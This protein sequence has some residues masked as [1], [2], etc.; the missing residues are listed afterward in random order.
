MSETTKKKSGMKIAF[1]LG[2]LVLLIAVFAGVYF[3]FAPKPSKGAKEIGIEVVDDKQASKSYTVN[4]DAE[5]LRQAIEE[6]E[7]LTVEGTE[8]SYGLMVTTVNGVVADYNTNGAYW[9]FYV[10]GEYCQYGIDTQPVENGQKYR[11]V[12]TKD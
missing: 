7:G 4:T 10:N 9:A 5:Y 6:T 11:I 12:Y 3:A 8:S 2:A 1:A